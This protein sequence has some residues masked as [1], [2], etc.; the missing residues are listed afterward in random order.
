M[1]RAVR[2]FR[3]QYAAPIRHSGTG[4]PAPSADDR[5]LT[6][7]DG[8][9]ALEEL[10]DRGVLSEQKLLHPS[11]PLLGIVDLVWRTEEGTHIADFKTGIP[12]DEHRAQVLCYGVLWWRATGDMPAALELRYPNEVIRV[13]AGCKE[14]EEAERDLTS[15]IALAREVFAQ[16]PAPAHPGEWCGYCDARPFCETYWGQFLVHW[17]A[18]ETPGTK[19]TAVDLEVTVESDPCEHGFEAATRDG[20][21]TSIVGDP[22]LF[23]ALGALSRGDRLRIIAASPRNG[24]REIELQRWTE[25]FHVA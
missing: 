7:G 19:T 1:N 2:L 11:L 20:R 15:R 18:L 16:K 3:A 10:A 25:V 9:S 4:L 14:L 21:R 23:G 5:V 6:T 24:G 17:K 22:N 13:S 12:S 8:R